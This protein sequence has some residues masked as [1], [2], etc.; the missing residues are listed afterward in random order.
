MKDANQ[1]LKFHSDVGD[2]RGPINIY[3]KYDYA[4]GKS[5]PKPVTPAVSVLSTVP[6]RLFD[7]SA[8]QLNLVLV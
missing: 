8:I 7:G 4:T 1:Y 3:L 2:S 5:N 6:L